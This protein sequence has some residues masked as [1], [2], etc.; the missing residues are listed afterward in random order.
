MGKTELIT[1]DFCNGNLM[2]FTQE[3]FLKLREDHPEWKVSRYGCLTNCGE[4]AARPFAILNDEIVTA[5]TPDELYQK[6]T[7]AVAAKA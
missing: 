5:E 1:L 6:I 3:L 7:E 2:S 4:C